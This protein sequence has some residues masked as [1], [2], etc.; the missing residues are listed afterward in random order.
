MNIFD[1]LEW[2]GLVADCTDAVELKKRSRPARLSFT[3]I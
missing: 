2:R 3:R 1:E